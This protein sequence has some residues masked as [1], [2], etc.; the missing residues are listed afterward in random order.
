MGGVDIRVCT[1]A[2]ITGALYLPT[3]STM[4][5]SCFQAIIPYVP[6]AAPQLG[7]LVY[8]MILGHFLTHDKQVSVHRSSFLF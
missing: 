7:Q 6:T 4:T 1:K 3:I 8:G 2:P 5:D